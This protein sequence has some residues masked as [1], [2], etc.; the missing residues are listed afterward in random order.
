MKVVC[1]CRVAAILWF[2]QDIIIIHLT[3]SCRQPPN[4]H[5]TES[6]Y[7]TSSLQLL[8]PSQRGSIV[9][10]FRLR[11]ANFVREFV[12]LSLELPLTASASSKQP[13]RYN[14]ATQSTSILYSDG[15]IEAIARARAQS[16]GRRRSL[17]LIFLPLSLH[18][19][20]RR[21]RRMMT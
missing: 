9:R 12:N 18:R 10:P 7:Y 13:L 2:D 8:F 1:C 15:A 17:A 3:A 6:R 19:R 11:S 21:L 16:R 4:N 20:R 14:F 5:D